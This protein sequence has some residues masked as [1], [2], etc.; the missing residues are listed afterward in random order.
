MNI[1]HIIILILSITSLSINAQIK[2]SKIERQPKTEP[3]IQPYDSL[4]NI[5]RNNL[6]SLVGQKVQVLPQI[7]ISD[8]PTGPTLYSSIP[9]PDRNSNHLVINPDTRYS[10]YKSQTGA[11]DNEI[12]NIVGV[13]SISSDYRKYFYLI[14]S[15]INYPS[16]NFIEV[17]SVFESSVSNHREEI[18][19]NGLIVI[20]YFDKLRSMV[21]GKKFINKYPN[22]KSWYLSD[23]IIYNLSD[24]SPLTSIPKDNLWEVVDLNFI[25]TENYAKLSYILSSDSI[26]NVFCSAD[27]KD[28]CLIPYEQFVSENKKR[29]DWE[30]TMIR[31]YGKA[32]GK[33]IIEG[34]VKVGFTK[35]MCEESW[36]KPSKINSS[37]GSWGVHEQWVYGSETYLYFKNGRLSSISN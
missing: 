19:P 20:G 11:F 3:I 29:T 30:K 22:N 7:Q 28:N 10:V 33:L 6:R 35:K 21:I 27:E 24:G 8:Y 25:E 31:K 5:T 18:H 23:Y 13:D 26:Q 14:V 34:R 37:S 17:G 4:T 2:A 1:K 9:D 16:R 32:N 15:N 12:F 36:G